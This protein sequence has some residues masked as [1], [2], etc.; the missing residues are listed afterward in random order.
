MVRVSISLCPHDVVFPDK[1][2]KEKLKKAVCNKITFFEMMLKLCV[3]EE[4]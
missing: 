2:K 3:K 4:R 1:S